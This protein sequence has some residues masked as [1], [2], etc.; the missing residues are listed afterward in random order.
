MQ[1]VPPTVIDLNPSPDKAAGKK[2]Q[3]SYD[4]I[5]N[6]ALTGVALSVE[7]MTDIISD[8]GS[9]NK[10]RIA[11]AKMLLEI[12]MKIAEVKVV[13]DLPLLKRLEEKCRQA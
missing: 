10:D 11:A 13:E 3:I 4:S 8:D 5:L 12:L 9:E 6:D 1:L 2:S 7:R